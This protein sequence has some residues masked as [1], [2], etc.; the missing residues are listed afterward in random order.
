MITSL[1]D[2]NIKIKHLCIKKIPHS[3]DKDKL[4]EKYG[5]NEDSIIEAIEHI[6]HPWCIGV[7]WHPEF[8]ITPSDKLLFKHFISITSN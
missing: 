3:G 8:L 5:I 4:M 6:D 1:L 2:N 7:Q